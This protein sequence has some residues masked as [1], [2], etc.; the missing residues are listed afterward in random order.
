MQGVYLYNW[1]IN[2][3]KNTVVMVTDQ[4]TIWQ[5]AGDPEHHEERQETTRSPAAYNHNN[6]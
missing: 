4:A 5:K 3:I 2:V 6:M 1:R